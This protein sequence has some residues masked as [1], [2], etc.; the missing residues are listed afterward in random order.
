MTICLARSSGDRRNTMIDYN[1]KK[2]ANSTSYYQSQ[3]DDSLAGTGMATA[4]IILW[5]SEELVMSYSY[6]QVRNDI[7][8]MHTTCTGTALPTLQA[9]STLDIAFEAQC[10][11]PTTTSMT[12]TTVSTNTA[13]TTTTTT[14]TTV[15]HSIVNCRY[16][17]NLFP[18]SSML[19]EIA[20]CPRKGSWR[21]S[22][23]SDVAPKVVTLQID[24]GPSRGWLFLGHVGLGLV[25]GNYGGPSFT[26]RLVSLGND[27]F[28]VQSGV[29]DN[30][31]NSYLAVD[32]PGQ[33]ALLKSKPSDERAQWM[34]AGLP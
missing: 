11:I 1:S 16:K 21:V 17:T 20:S 31:G 29:E 25:F 15:L 33:H 34:I 28:T 30:S 23:V 32:T 13:T 24:A 6:D 14:T 10:C 5:R 7:I 12:T 19:S 2:T 8:L 3:S 27:T 22:V 9:K 4:L 26:W 18:N